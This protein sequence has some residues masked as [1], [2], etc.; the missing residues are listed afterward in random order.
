MARAVW[1]GHISFGL[2]SVPVSLYAAENRTDLQLHMLDSR[3]HSRVRYERVNEETGQEVP[4]DVIV[5]GYEYSDGS[6]VVLSDEELKRAAPEATKTI[7]IEAF[8]AGEEI[9]PTFYDKPYF[10]EPGKG[11][12]K[13][14]VLLHHALAES[15]R[16]GIARVVIR[17]RQY[18]AA[19]MPHNDVLML[20]LLRYGQ[21]LRSAADLDIPKG[22]A[23]ANGVTAQ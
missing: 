19:L 6:Y 2:V 20:I 5:R 13:G 17:T 1:R 10:L 15:K 23:K 12:K 3:D 22:G 16:V 8:V 4:W 18:I 21:E 7:D 9:D 14:Y 11:S